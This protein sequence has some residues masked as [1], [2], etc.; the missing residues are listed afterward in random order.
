[1]NLF[2]RTQSQ[3]HICDSKTVLLLRILGGRGF[4]LGVKKIEAMLREMLD[5]KRAAESPAPSP[6]FVGCLMARVRF[7][8][9]DF[10]ISRVCLLLKVSSF[11]LFVSLVSLLV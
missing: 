10:F 6:R 1:M 8:P 11:H 9:S 7:V 5:A 4:C 2:P 3:N